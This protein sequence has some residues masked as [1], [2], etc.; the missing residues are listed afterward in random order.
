MRQESL[1]ARSTVPIIAELAEAADYAVAGDQNCNRV[2]PHGAPNRATGRGLPDLAGDLPVSGDAPRGNA[3]QRLP[4]L[5]LEIGAA[6]M[7]VQRFTNPAAEVE[8]GL[9]QP[10]SD[11]VVFHH[12]GVRPLSDQIVDG[13]AFGVLHE[14]QMANTAVR[15]AD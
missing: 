11:T 13:I 6:Q 1:L 5:D 9:D 4:D 15:D 14:S 8:Y 3:Q 12:G 7:H 10:G 2:M